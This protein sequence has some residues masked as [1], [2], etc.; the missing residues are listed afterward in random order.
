M[1]EKDFIGAQWGD[2]AL[3]PTVRWKMSKEQLSWKVV[4][5]SS[6][7]RKAHWAQWDSL[8]LNNDMLYRHWE[9]KQPTRSFAIFASQITSTRCIVAAP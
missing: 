2:K 7:T 4:L 8:F 1:V 9:A 3:S 6:P 5:S